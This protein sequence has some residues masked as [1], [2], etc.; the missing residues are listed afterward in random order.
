MLF[1]VWCV[2]CLR[3]TTLSRWW[4]WSSWTP[5]WTPTSTWSVRSTPTLWL[6]A[7]IG[8]SSPDGFP[9]KYESTT[10]RHARTHKYTHTQTHT[11]TN[12]HIEAA[13]IQM[14]W[15]NHGDCF[16][17]LMRSLT[18]SLSYSLMVVMETRYLSF[19]VIVSFNSNIPTLWSD[20]TE[21]GPRYWSHGWCVCLVIYNLLIDLFIGFVDHLF[22]G[23]FYHSLTPDW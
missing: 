22:W 9:S 13:L 1:S 10:N 8:T 3:W 14:L 23:L 21:D 11:H 16:S 17:V 19:P 20:V 7:A 18:F 2:Q 4:L 15:W 6:T 5:P 12:T